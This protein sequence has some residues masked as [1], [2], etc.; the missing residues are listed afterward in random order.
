MRLL[1]ETIVGEQNRIA[2]LRREDV[3]AV[4]VAAAAALVAMAADGRSVG[5]EW[6][7]RRRARET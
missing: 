7:C 6:C 1:L 4:S 2:Y 5:V 3:A